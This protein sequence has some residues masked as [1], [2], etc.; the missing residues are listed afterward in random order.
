MNLFLVFDQALGVGE[1][2]LGIEFSAVLNAHLKGFYKCTYMDGGEKKN[3]A[4][5]QF[6]PVD[7]RRCF[8]C[9]D[10]PALKATFKIAVDVP[11]ELTA[12]SNMPIINEKLDANVKTVYFEES[13]IMST[14][15]VAVV[16]GV[17]D[18]IEDTTSDGVLVRAYCPVGKSDKGEF[19]LNVAVKTLDLFS[20][21]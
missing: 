21:S 5:T 20:N 1:G 19:A 7:A 10:E 3:M 8:P 18:Y 16:V 11:P 15:L 6:E 2:V 13:P 4:V 12:L 17:F 9:W 14:Y